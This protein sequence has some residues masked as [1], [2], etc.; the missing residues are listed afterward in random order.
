MIRAGKL[1]AIFFGLIL[2]VSNLAYPGNWQ[3]ETS[4]WNN[5]PNFIF[6]NDPSLVYPLRGSGVRLAAQ[7]SAFGWNGGTIHQAVGPYG[8]YEIYAR[9]PKGQG[10]WPAL[11]LFSFADQ[12][13]VDI[14]EMIDPDCQNLQM[15]VHDAWNAAQ[16]NQ[17][18]V[19]KVDL[20]RAYHRYGLRWTADSLKFYL[21]GKQI[22]QTDQYVPSEPMDL[23]LALAVGGWAGLPDASTPNPAHFDIQYVRT[24]PDHTTI[25]AQVLSRLP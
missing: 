20:S 16:I 24:W 1:F 9:L 6:T 25:P 7:P 2:T 18:Y 13:E 8:Y 15:T 3:Y 19:G 11:F 10:L 4:A 22:W 5:G 12:R 17:E 21:D 23:Y 14:F